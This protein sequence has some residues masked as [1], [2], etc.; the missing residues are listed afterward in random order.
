MTTPI[1]SELSIDVSVPDTVVDGFVS[2]GLPVYPM[3]VG[4]FNHTQVPYKNIY[5]SYG[6][7]SAYDAATLDD[8]IP[9]WLKEVL[10]TVD[11]GNTDPQPVLVRETH[12]SR[13]FYI[14]VTVTT[15]A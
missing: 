2:E 4:R 8:T 14:N 1:N 10:A 7:I 5:Q 13:F 15:G 11:S 3:T 6:T 9:T 12:N